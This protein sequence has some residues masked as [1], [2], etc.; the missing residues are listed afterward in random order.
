MNHRTHSRQS[1]VGVLLL[2]LLLLLRL[3]PLTTTAL[4]AEEDL[5]GMPYHPYR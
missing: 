2:T 4:A 3:S 1:K 5:G